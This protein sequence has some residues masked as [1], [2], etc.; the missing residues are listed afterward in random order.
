MVMVSI[1]V[2]VTVRRMADVMNDS[3]APFITIRH[4]FFARNLTTTLALL[5]ESFADSDGRLMI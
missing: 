4:Q 3:I 5:T 2:T 1:I